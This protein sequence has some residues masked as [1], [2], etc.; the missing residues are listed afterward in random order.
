MRLSAL[1]TCLVEVKKNGMCAVC[2]N[3]YTSRNTWRLIV[4]LHFSADKPYIPS[5]YSS[6]KFHF[7]SV[8]KTIACWQKQQDF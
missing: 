4:I 5:K 3:L 2:Y 6:V 1:M 7:D 8:K